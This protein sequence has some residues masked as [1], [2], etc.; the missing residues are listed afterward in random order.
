MQGSL[1]ARLALLAR[2]RYRAVFSVAGLL[3]GISL[4]LASRLTFDTD[5]LNLLPRQDPVIG[6][7]V[8]TLSDFGAN[9]FLLV[10]LR[11]PEGGRLEP[12]EGLADDLAGRLKA[13]PDLKS[14]EY[15]IGDP[16]EL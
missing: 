6:A 5:M 9:S 7:Y 2:R 13:L 16:Q 3:V 12:Y 11:V 14:V 8:Q 4:L 15:R 1:L 10:A